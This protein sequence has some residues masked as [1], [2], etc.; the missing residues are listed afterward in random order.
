MILVDRWRIR[1]PHDKA[2]L[3]TAGKIIG[4]VSFRICMLEVEGDVIDVVTVRKE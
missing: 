3:N 4:R 1:I 2:E